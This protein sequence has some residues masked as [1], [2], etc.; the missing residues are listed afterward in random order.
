[1][2][3][4]S[5]CGRQAGK[6]KRMLRQ[7]ILLFPGLLHGLHQTR[8]TMADFRHTL[9]FMTADCGAIFDRIKQLVVIFRAS[10]N[11]RVSGPFCCEDFSTSEIKSMEVVAQR[12]ATNSVAASTGIP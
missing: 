11:G 2:Q 10:E 3:K 12:L 4:A 8:L 7:S 1:M 6:V 5:V 9:G